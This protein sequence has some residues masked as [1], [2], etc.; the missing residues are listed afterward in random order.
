[1]GETKHL[2][3]AVELRRRLGVTKVIYGPLTRSY[4]SPAMPVHGGKKQFVLDSEDGSFKAFL[5]TAEN[6]KKRFRSINSILAR[7][8]VRLFDLFGFRAR[9]KP[10]ARRTNLQLEMIRKCS[11]SV[12]KEIEWHVGCCYFVS[13]SCLIIREDEETLEKSRLVAF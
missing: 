2:R 8:V 5:S 4:L 9:A 12:I 10:Q 1:M 6:Q 11:L 7:C 3:L 13:F